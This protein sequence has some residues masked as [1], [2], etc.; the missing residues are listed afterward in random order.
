MREMI[1]KLFI[2]AKS[3]LIGKKEIVSNCELLLSAEQE[4]VFKALRKTTLKPLSQGVAIYARVANNEDVG[5]AKQ[6][7]DLENE[8]EL[9]GDTDITIYSEVSS[10]ISKNESERSELYRLIRDA[11]NGHIKRLYVKCRDRI[12]RDF[13]FTREVAERL[14]S[15]GV[16]LI[17]VQ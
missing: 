8:A 10:G 2:I 9:V 13:V 5:L 3:R 16:E 17:E 1:K 15:F 11:E 6:I 4:D 7:M 14:N 12:A